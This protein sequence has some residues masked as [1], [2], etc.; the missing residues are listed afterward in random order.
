[1]RITVGFDDSEELYGL[2]LVHSTYFDIG[3][4][5]IQFP[6]G[7]MI[8]LFPSFWFIIDHTLTKYTKEIIWI[9]LSKGIPLCNSSL[10]LERKALKDGIMRKDFQ[11]P[12]VS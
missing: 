11:H 12:I 1:M 5:S 2:K 7:S 6:F 8:F 4:I 3:I 10:E 9:I